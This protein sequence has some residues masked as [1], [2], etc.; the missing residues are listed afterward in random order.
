M[1]R[2][3][4]QQALDQLYRTQWVLNCEAS[5]LLDP[6]VSILKAELAKP[7]QES[8]KPRSDYRDW[9][10]QDLLDNPE[11]E[12]EIVRRV[13]RYR[14]KRRESVGSPHIT[15]KECIALA[16]WIDSMLSAPPR[17]PWVGLTDDEVVACWARPDMFAIAHAIE[18]KLKKKNI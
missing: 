10:Y 14:G 11:Q 9:D 17:K 7:E 12:P 4:L 8:V 18:I 1:S 2:E 15:A 13:K 6:V 3:L 5:Y 16:N